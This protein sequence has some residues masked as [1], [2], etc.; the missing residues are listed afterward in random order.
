[1]YDPVDFTVTQYTGNYAIV[2]NTLN[3]I[4]A[5]RG[6]LPISTTS[7]RADA[8]DWDGITTYSTFNGSTLSP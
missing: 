7:G 2:D 4:E 1:M 5:P 8:R 6:P 3:F